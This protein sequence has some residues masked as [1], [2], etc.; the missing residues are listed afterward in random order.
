VHWCAAATERSRGTW[1]VRDPYN[2]YSTHE[3][4]A[5]KYSVLFA[6]EDTVL[7]EGDGITWLELFE[8]FRRVIYDLSLKS[9]FLV[10]LVDFNE[11]EHG[12]ILEGHEH[13]LAE[14]EDV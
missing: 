11:L 8:R 6:D 12:V 5:H 9:A 10:L 14:D 13:L 7:V 4:F 2:I 3:Q 1:S